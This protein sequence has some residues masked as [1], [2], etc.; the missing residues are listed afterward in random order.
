MGLATLEETAL[1][2]RGTL[3][4][5]G[6]DTGSRL[7]PLHQVKHMHIY[8]CALNQTHKPSHY[9]LPQKIDTIVPY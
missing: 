6:W 2:L 3:W 8:P 1:I 7:S 9:S 5:H 4:P